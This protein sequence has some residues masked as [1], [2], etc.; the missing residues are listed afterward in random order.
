MNNYDYPVGADNSDAP[1]NQNDTDVGECP[2][3]FGELTFFD[4]GVYR[5]VEWFSYK[6]TCCGHIVSDEEDYDED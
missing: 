3:C 6:C 4:S 5:G 1:W 2:E